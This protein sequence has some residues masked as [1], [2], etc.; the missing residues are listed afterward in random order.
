M[1]VNPQPIA[2][3]GTDAHGAVSELRDRPPAPGLYR[4]RLE[5]VDDA[6]NVSPWGEPFEL[7]VR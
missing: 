5:L 2:A 1:R 4:Y 6:G 3:W 7:E